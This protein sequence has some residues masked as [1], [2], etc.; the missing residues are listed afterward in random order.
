MQSLD[1]RGR[2]MTLCDA[3]GRPVKA[4]QLIRS[5]RTEVHTLRGGLAPQK[6]GSTGRVWTDLGE[7]YPSVFD[8]HWIEQCPVNLDGLNRRELLFVCLEI[9]NRLGIVPM[10]N[11][12]TT[13]LRQHL[14]G[15]DITEPTND[16]LMAALEAAAMDVNND[17]LFCSVLE[18]AA[19]HIEAT[20]NEE[21]KP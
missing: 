10:L 17:P 3:T 19:A 15:L 12:T 21:P 18:Y 6:E 7:Y 20:L 13:D 8:L 9:Q 2:I 11:V 5:F 1:H 16:Q 4:G 14:D